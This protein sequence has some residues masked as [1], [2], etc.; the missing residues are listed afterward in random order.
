MSVGPL[1]DPLP[2][3][4]GVKKLKDAMETYEFLPSPSGR[5]AG[6]EGL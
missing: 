6:E 1:P 2:E 5:R 4:E 3:G